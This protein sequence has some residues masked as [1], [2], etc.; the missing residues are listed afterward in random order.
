[1]SAKAGNVVEMRASS[2]RPRNIRYRGDS[3]ICIA[4]MPYASAG[5]IRVMNIHH[6]A[7]SPS[8]RSLFALQRR[9]PGSRPIA[10][11][12]RCRRLWPAVA[13]SRAGRGSRQGYLR[14]VDRRDDPGRTDAEARRSPRHAG[15]IR[16]WIS[17]SG[18]LATSW[19]GWHRGRSDGD[20]T[21][22]QQRQDTGF[23]PL[24]VIPSP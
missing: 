24:R 1:M 16:S 23:G 7:A 18:T 17:G 21:T 11:P 10:A 13:G 6:Q 15:P 9:W 14:D 22:T 4:R 12:R 5:T 20:M 19:E 3:G 8:Q 2:V